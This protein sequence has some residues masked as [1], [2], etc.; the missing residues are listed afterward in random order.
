MAEEKNVHFVVT[1]SHQIGSGGASI[2]EKLAEKW[3]VP[4]VDRE[5]LKQVAAE[6][7]MDERDVEKR[8]ER[9]SGFWQRFARA[10]LIASPFVEPTPE[11]YLTDRDLFE[12]ESAYIERI[13]R[14]TPAVI[15]GRGAGQILAAHPR[16]LRVL[17]CANA[18]ERLE[19][20]RALY[21]MDAEGAE[22]L[23]E[24]NDRERA[25]YLRTFTRHD[26]FDA[27]CYDVCLN[28]SVTGLDGAADIIARL[29][30]KKLRLTETHA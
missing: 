6:Y 17:L 12:M 11:T 25:A 13:V 14:K 24:K 22:R 16:H 19:R 3:R 29:A 28:T 7:R 21:K 5:I 4:F 23:L 10:E 8:E 15:L 30:G 18:P 26:V 27:R 1:I 20:I 9:L 2:G